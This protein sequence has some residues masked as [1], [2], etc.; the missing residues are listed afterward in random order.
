VASPDVFAIYRYRVE[1]V[2]DVDITGYAVHA[3]DGDIGHVDKHD[4][5]A[6]SA[7]LV[8]KTG[9]W[10][11]GRTVMLPAG[12]IQRVDPEHETVY[13][14]RSKDEIKAAPEYREDGDTDQ[15]YRSELGDYYTGSVDQF[16]PGGDIRD[17]RPD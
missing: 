4:A 11:L 10:I 9:P 12:V 16:G 5:E 7:H 6:G 14:N 3:T 2:A 15:E 1:V 13:V 8:I 17:P